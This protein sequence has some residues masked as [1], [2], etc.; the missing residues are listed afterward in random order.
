MVVT[1][2]GLAIVQKGRL[3]HE[4]PQLTAIKEASHNENFSNT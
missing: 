4:S 1:V 3:R 2:P